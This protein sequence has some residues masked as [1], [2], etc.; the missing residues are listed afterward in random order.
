MPR[1]LAGYEAESEVLP[2]YYV[3][4]VGVEFP[5]GIL[6]EEVERLRGDFMLRAGK[7]SALP[8]AVEHADEA[9]IRR[10]HYPKRGHPVAWRFS[11]A[12]L[13]DDVDEFLDQLVDLGATIT[14]LDVSVDVS[15]ATFLLS[16]DVWVTYR[17]G[18]RWRRPPQ[19]DK[20]G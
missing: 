9:T 11:A 8:H 4:T 5:S 12:W 6:V 3:D 2:A 14:R 18:D 7:N 19:R 15:T 20:L 1:P 13:G 17:P 10:W 16:S